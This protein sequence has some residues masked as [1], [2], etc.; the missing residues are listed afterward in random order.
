MVNFVQFKFPCFPLNSVQGIF[1]YIFRSRYVGNAIYERNW[2][3]LAHD[4]GLDST[5]FESRQGKN[6]FLF[7][8]T[9]R[10]AV[11]LTVPQ[12]ELVPLIFL[13]RKAAG[14]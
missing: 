11:R 3:L 6:I 14:K 4:Q 8:E 10:P 13:S 5:V 12:I 1:V 9:L 7:P 2:E